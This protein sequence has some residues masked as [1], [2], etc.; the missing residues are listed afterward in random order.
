MEDKWREIHMK[1]IEREVRVERKGK[2]KER[3]KVCE[4]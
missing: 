3:E 1:V 2:K 4:E